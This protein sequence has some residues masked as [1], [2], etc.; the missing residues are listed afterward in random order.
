MHT[1]Y[2]VQFTFTVVS[3]CMDLLGIADKGGENG[4]R[5]RPLDVLAQ[6]RHVTNIT[7]HVCVTERGGG[8]G[9]GRERE[10]G[11]EGERE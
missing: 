10:G 5:C 9:G 8:G 4:G 1:I 6:V 7:V 3:P 2:T 11:R